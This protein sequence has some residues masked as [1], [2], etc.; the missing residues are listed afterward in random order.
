MGSC[1][2]SGICWTHAKNHVLADA[3][4]TDEGRDQARAV[5]IVWMQELKAG[6]PVPQHFYCSPLSRAL[7]TCVLT[8]KDVTSISQENSTIV[9]VR[10]AFR[11]QVHYS[12]QIC[13]LQNC[14]EMYGDHSCDMRRT[15]TEIENAFPQFSFENGFTEK[16]LLH[17]PDVRESEEHL[18]ERGRKVLEYIFEHTDGNGSSQ[19]LQGCLV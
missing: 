17:D 12:N 4:L 10:E 2:D 14:R 5:G 8:F 18:V 15:R 3:L 6:I 16:D 13:P 1:V 19:S 7:E 9:E 11:V